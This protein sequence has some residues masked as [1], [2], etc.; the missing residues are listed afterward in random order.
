MFGRDN[1]YETLNIDVNASP[2]EIKKSYFTAVRKY[3]PERFPSEFKRIREAYEVL[4]DISSKKEYDEV[5][6]SDKRAEKHFKLG[7]KAYEEEDYEKAIEQLEIASR[8][9]PKIGFVRNLLGLSYIEVENYKK[10]VEIFKKLIQDYPGKPIYYKHL[11]FSMLEKNA[12]K[13]AKTVFEKGLNLDNT[14]FELWLGLSLCLFKQKNFEQSRSILLDGIKYCGENISLYLEMIHIDIMQKDMDN[15]KIDVEKLTNI[16]KDDEKLKENISWSLA[17][18]ATELIMARMVE[19][20]AKILEKA[21]ELNPD[22]K[23]IKALYNDITKTNQLV[24]QLNNLKEEKSIHPMLLE[25]L[26]EEIF[27]VPSFLGDIAN[28]YKDMI[29]DQAG[30]LIPSVRYLKENYPK[31]YKL[32]KDLFDRVLESS[33]QIKIGDEYLLT[34][35]TTVVRKQKIGRNDPCPCGSGKKYKKCCLDG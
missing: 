7:R 35:G 22:E 31:L 30:M 16:A 4:S 15:L 3:P 1:Y 10:G 12:F 9:A 17:K 8:I 6:T 27:K 26:E 21:L 2:T 14:D 34:E 25:F 28:M 20:S 24:Y 5:I 32:K 13:Q 18:I 19:Y 33:Q 11:G 29:L 23:H